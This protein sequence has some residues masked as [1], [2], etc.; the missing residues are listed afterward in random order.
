MK[1]LN[2]IYASWLK[3]F[4]TAVLVEYSALLSTGGN[5]FSWDLNMIERL[6]TVGILSLIPVV[7]NYLN[8]SDTRYGRT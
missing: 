1:N 8:P 2:S 7:V 4:V 3:V 6:L 5:L